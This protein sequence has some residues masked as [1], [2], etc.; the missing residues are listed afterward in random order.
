MTETIQ[1]KGVGALRVKIG[2]TSKVD[3]FFLK[4][5]YRCLLS[6]NI[7]I[8]YILLEITV[9][10]VIKVNPF[11]NTKNEFLIN[12]ETSVVIIARI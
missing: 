8:L 3:N 5:S 7:Y 10:D 4:I 6:K 1:N 9:Y 2:P 12:F 11:I